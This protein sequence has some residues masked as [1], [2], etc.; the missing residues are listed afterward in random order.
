MLVVIVVMVGIVVTVMMV[1]VNS[2]DGGCDVTLL[3]GVGD[4]DKSLDIEFGDNEIQNAYFDGIRN[5]IQQHF[6]DFEGCSAD[7]E[8]AILDVLVK[9]VV[10]DSV[11]SLSIPSE[12]PHIGNWFSSYAYESPVLRGIDD[13]QEC[14]DSGGVGKRKR[15]DLGE[16]VDGRRN[17]L[18]CGENVASEGDIELPIKDWRASD[19]LSFSSGKF[20]SSTCYEVFLTSVLFSGISVKEVK[21]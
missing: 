7:I 4:T 13:F 15:D 14:D 20:G 16:E 9:A 5:S 10:L 8:T 17:S 2:G 21:F 6:E 19:N 3:D 18:H 11:G 1:A 12:P